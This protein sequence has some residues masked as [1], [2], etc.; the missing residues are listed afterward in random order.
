LAVWQIEQ[1]T[2]KLKSTNIKSFPY[3]VRAKAIAH[4]EVTWWVFVKG[5]RE[6]IE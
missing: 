6:S 5:F 1:P 4:R 2:A 3:F